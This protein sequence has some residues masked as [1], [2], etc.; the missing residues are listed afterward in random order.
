MNEEQSDH[1]LKSN[2]IAENQEELDEFLVRLNVYAM[3]AKDNVEKVILEIAKQ[4]LISN[5]YLVISAWQDIVQELKSSAEFRSIEALQ[6]CYENLEPIAKKVLSVM[7]DTPQ[8]DGK[9][10]GVRYLQ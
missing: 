3:V 10:D 1:V 6:L 5:L 7:K 4:E 2:N 9:M 8:N